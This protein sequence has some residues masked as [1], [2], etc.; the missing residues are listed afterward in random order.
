MKTTRVI[1]TKECPW[2]AYDI[3]AGLE[4]FEYKGHTYNLISNKGIA[5]TFEED[6]S[7]FLEIPKDSIEDTNNE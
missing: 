1:T 3:P 6:S 7:Y 5:V 4:V 2:L